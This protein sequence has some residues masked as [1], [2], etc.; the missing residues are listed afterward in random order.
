MVVVFLVGCDAA[1][2]E[3][4][5]LLV[6]EAFVMS[7]ESFPN[8]ILRRAAPLKDPYLL[9]SSTA[10]MDARV[11]LTQNGILVPYQMQVPGVYMPLNS[12]MATPG[13]RIALNV[14]WEDQVASAETRIPPLISMDRIEIS[15]TDTPVPG[16]LLDSL[17][18]D[19][20]QIDSL[21]IRALGTG[22]REGL[23]HLVRATV[24]WDDQ[25]GRDDNQWWIRMQL[26]P[27]LT[28]DQRLSN[29]FLSSEVLRPEKEMSFS[30]DHLRSWSGSYAVPVTS[31]TDPITEHRL[32]IS[33]IRSTEAYAGFVSQSS[34][35][36]EYE[37]PSNI[38][39]GR[40]IFAGLAIDTITVSIK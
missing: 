8:I 17:F 20:T 27:T 16:L 11:E 19:P 6:V 12:M 38:S 40:G 13:D 25:T 21:G 18:I 9:N 37:P 7:E 23:V 10:A 1:Q 34:N 33:I 5:S 2:P 3:D 39:G 22:A 24:H 31:Q 35:P 26:L 15:T 30:P 4:T 14:Q 29:Y 36:S 28:Q 32:R